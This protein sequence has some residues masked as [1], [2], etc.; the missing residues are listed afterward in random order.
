MKLRRL[1]NS[2]E[3]CLFEMRFMTANRV[4][5]QGKEKEVSCPRLQLQNAFL[6]VLIMADVV[7]FQWVK[8]NRLI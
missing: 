3:H 4:C 7:F 5:F 8:S 6:R 2:T 1:Q